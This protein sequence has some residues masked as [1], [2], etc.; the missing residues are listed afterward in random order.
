[1]SS[2]LKFIPICILSLLLG[3]AGNARADPTAFVTFYGLNVDLF[4]LNPTDRIV[5]QMSLELSESFG[6]VSQHSLPEASWPPLREEHIFIRGGTNLADSNGSATVVMLDAFKEAQAVSTGAGSYAAAL[7][8]KFTFTLTPQTR[9]VF[10]AL[11]ESTVTATSYGSAIASVGLAGRL[12]N[13]LGQAP[14]FESFNVW[15][16]SGRSEL[17]VAVETASGDSPL[18]GEIALLGNVYATSALP[19]PEPGQFAMLLAGIGMVAGALR[20]RRVR[21]VM[22][23]ALA[24]AAALA[25][26]SAHASRGAASVSNFSYELF[27]L[28]PADGITPSLTITTGIVNGAVFANVNNEPGDPWDEQLFSTDSF[29]ETAI[30]KAQGHAL[31]E[32][33]PW[34]ARAEA[35]AGRGAFAGEGSSGYGFTLTPNTRVRFSADAQVDVF[36]DHTNTPPDRSEAAA[37]LTGEIASFPGQR[38]HF[39]SFLETGTPTEGALRLAVDAFTGEFAGTGNIRAQ[40]RALAVG[41]SPIPEPAPWVLLVA[42]LA[43]CGVFKVSSCAQSRPLPFGHARVPRSPAAPAPAPDPS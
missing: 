4:D 1:M 9:A 2:S 26:G 33:S 36:H 30:D 16:E 32:L 22:A 35:A 28:V 21:A 8:D 40:T 34:A 41:V 29:G 38:T 23:G 43:S 13:V 3:L 42:G 15:T 11:T 24:A 7:S 27:D 14:T 18:E 10:S 19:I 6:S 31:V 12:T 17:P 20:R 5:P 37:G 39:E 25:T